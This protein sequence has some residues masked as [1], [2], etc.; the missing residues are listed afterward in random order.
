MI[1]LTQIIIE[2]YD[3]TSREEIYQWLSDLKTL[4]VNTLKLVENLLQWSR[5]QTGAISFHPEKQD[6]GK[7]AESVCALLTQT[8]KLKNIQ[9]ICSIPEN[10]ILVYDEDMIET[11][12]RNLIA[13]A[14]KY[15]FQGNNI[16]VSHE[17]R[18][19]EFCFMVADKGKGMSPDIKD[20][21]FRIEK[22]AS[23][24]GTSGEAGTGLGLI[25][26]KEFVGKH[27]GQIG[28]DS[29]PGEGTT[30]SF[31]IP[32]GIA[33]ASRIAEGRNKS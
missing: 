13:N 14:I 7:T 6:A 23:E 12:F 31:T 9:I 3:A 32:K 10:T 24:R 28:V 25:V 16:V 17:E 1:G 5:V 4:S 20:R 15:S 26:C 29:I 30:F 8:A 27:G 2:E 18:G 22:A 33:A 11:V 19:K 21:L